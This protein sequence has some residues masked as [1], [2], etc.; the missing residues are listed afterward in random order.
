MLES[1][2]RQYLDVC[3]FNQLNAVASL[4]PRLETVSF[5]DR[6]IERGYIELTPYQVGALFENQ[7]QQ[8]KYIVDYCAVPLQLIISLKQVEEIFFSYVSSDYCR[9]ILT[10]IGKQLIKIEFYHCEDMD[11]GCL[12]PCTNLEVLTIGKLCTVD[13]SVSIQNR[14]LL[15]KLKK[16]NIDHRLNGWSYLIPLGLV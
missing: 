2:V 8:V 14:I 7:L 4:C 16:L 11:L 13:A 12:L 15:P 1:S 3:S 10:T 9:A 6:Y 5:K